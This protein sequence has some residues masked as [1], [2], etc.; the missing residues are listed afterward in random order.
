M[1]CSRQDPSTVVG[2]SSHT[3]CWKNSFA[4]TSRR[5]SSFRSTKSI[6]KPVTPCRR[7]SSS[8]AARA[9]ATGSTEPGPSAGPAAPIPVP[10]RPSAN[11]PTMAMGCSTKVISSVVVFSNH[12]IRRS[13]TEPPTTSRSPSPS[14][15][16]G[17]ELMGQTIRVSSCSTHDVSSSGSPASSNQEMVLSASAS[18]D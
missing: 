1:G 7:F 14:R 11:V 10:D 12:R 9:F 18:P 8:P 15:S 17:W 6:L 2:C 13:A 5:P 3:R 4:T 16:T